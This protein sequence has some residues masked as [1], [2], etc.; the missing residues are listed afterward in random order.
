VLNRGSAKA[1]KKP[2]TKGS[3]RRR[4]SAYRSGRLELIGFKGPANEFKPKRTHSKKVIG[5][6]LNFTPLKNKS[7]R[8]Y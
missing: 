2:T 6:A 4:R 1:A 5:S 3:W 7:W 8:R